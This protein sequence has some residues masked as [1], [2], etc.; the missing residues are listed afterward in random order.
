MAGLLG[1]PD[2]GAAPLL[3]SMDDGQGYLAGSQA[4]WNALSP[5]LSGAQVPAQQAGVLGRMYSAWKQWR[6]ANMQHTLS[7]PS[8][9]LGFAGVTEPV[10][11]IRAFHGSPYDFDAFDLSKIG[12]GEG[13]QAYGHGLYF[14]GN[15]NVAKGYRDTL[16]KG[17]ADVSGAPLPSDVQ[18]ALEYV[19]PKYRASG[20]LEAGIQDAIANL[21]DQADFYRRTYG[22]GTN[23]YDHAVERLQRIDPLSLKPAGH[24]YEVNIAADPSQLLD[25][26]KP[27]GRQSQ[28][29][30]DALAKNPSP[31]IQAWRGNGAWPNARGADAYSSLSFGEPPVGF[32]E[33]GNALFNGVSALNR[34]NPAGA[35]TWLNQAG[36]PGI[37]YLD[38]GSRAA[39]DGTRNYVIFDPRLISILRKYAIPPLAAGGAATPFLLGNQQQQ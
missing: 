8:A 37:Q 24:M 22:G 31:I 9:I 4:L 23:L 25:W 36:I 33:K 38:Q 26:D 2:P 19:H 6:D 34:R 14:A 29:V 30:Q 7:D 28:A 39:G 17:Y 32:D 27:L 13:A 10:G 15:E 20:D 12:T 11:G 5:N 18:A 21:K 3:G 35:S 1:S 16:A